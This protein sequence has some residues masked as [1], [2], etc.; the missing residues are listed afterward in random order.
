MSDQIHQDSTAI[1]NCAHSCDKC[2]A[3]CPSRSASGGASEAESFLEKPHAG[4]Y[5]KHVIGIV[6]GKGG[7][8]KSLVTGI[9]ASKLAKAGYKVGILDGDITGPSIPREFG[10]RDH[11]MGTESGLLPLVSKGGVKIMSI[12][13]LLRD[14]TDPVVWRGPVIAGVIKQFWTEVIWGEL[15]YLLIDMPPGTS[16]V[17]LTVYQ[18]IPIDGILVVTSPQDLVSMVVTKAVQMARMMN[19]RVMGLVENMSYLV[20][21]DCGKRISV[22]GESRAVENANALGCEVVG[23]I[24]IDSSM[25]A[26]VDQG[27]IEAIEAHYLDPAIIKLASLDKPV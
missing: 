14:E 1:E 12:N 16:D 19:I 6:S 27:R 21:P 22:F 18:S 26:L 23:E 17:P 10:I 15:D 9:L 2:G 3:D 24:P 8:G 25:T 4:S 7:V 13:L 11:A 20:C 5:I